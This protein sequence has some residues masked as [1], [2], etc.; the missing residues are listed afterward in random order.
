MIL[1]GSTLED[2]CQSAMQP[3]LTIG[4]HYSREGL[5]AVLREHGYHDVVTYVDLRSIRCCHL[6]ENV[7]R[8][9]SNLGVVA[10]DDG[11]HGAYSA[12]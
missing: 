10:V 11:W 7:P 9:E 3:S 4:L 2:K 6:Y 1:T 12:L 8:L 5:L